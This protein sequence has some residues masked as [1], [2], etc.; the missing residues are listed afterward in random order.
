MSGLLSGLAP[1][2]L[3]GLALGLLSGLDLGL[4][5][6]L[7]L[8]WVSGLVLGLVSGITTGL[9]SSFDRKRAYKFRELSTKASPESVR[10]SGT[11]PMW[12]T[13]LAGSGLTLTWFLLCSLQ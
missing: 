11:G 10:G 7:A 4:L 8:G 1:G 12:P 9:K 13:A 6:G 2:L 3:S 5:S